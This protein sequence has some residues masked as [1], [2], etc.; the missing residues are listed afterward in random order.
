MPKNMSNEWEF[1]GKVLSWLQE[2][3]DLR[4]GLNL[5]QVTQEPSKITPKRNDLVVW[6]HRASGAA[7]LTFELKT[8]TTPIQD[9][10]LFADACEKARKWGARYFAIWNMQ[11]AELYRV[12][13]DAATTSL[14]DRIHLEP[15]NPSITSIDDWLNQQRASELKSVALR[16]LDK[17]WA[18]QAEQNAKLIEIEASVFVARLA[19]RLKALRACLYPALSAKASKSKKIKQRLKELATEQGFANFVDDIEEAISGQYAYRLIGQILFHFALRRRQPALSPLKINPKDP[20]PASF[21]PFWDEVRKF[22][23]EALFQWSE[24]DDIV[25]IPPEATLILFQMIEELSAYDWNKLRDDVLGAV[26]ERLIPTKERQ[27]L[28]QFYTPT[29]V[30]DLL[31]AFAVDGEDPFVLDPGCGSGTFVM[32]AYEYLRTRSPMKHGEALSKVW[33]FDISAFAAELASINLFRQDMSA[34]DNFPRIVCG[35][36]FDRFVGEERDFPPAKAGGQG[37]VTL[38]I[39]QFAAIVAN[40]PYLRSQNQDDL[41]TAYK[42][43]LFNSAAKNGVNANAKT[44][45]FAFFIY[46]S[47]EFLAPSGRLAFVVSSSWLTAD[48]GA[49]LQRVLLDKLKPVAIIMSQAESFFSQADVNAV[50][51]IAEKGTASATDPL[52]F[53]MLKRRLKEIFAGGGK[54]YWDSVEALAQEIESTSQSVETSEYRLT[55]VQSGQERTAMDSDT[56]RPRNWSLFLRAPSAYFQ[57]FGGSL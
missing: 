49:T 11:M 42:T 57:L 43:S 16:L 3:I 36:Y 10:I 37:K 44:D 39:P 35:N 55:V 45:L 26:F 31:I 30:A 54:P 4:P 17:A 41:S 53:V 20:L 40:P 33:G 21:K 7:F 19:E 29:E 51:L 15:L 32:R 9:P 5:E 2:E 28:G 48:F 13:A 8:P 25:P 56:S 18:D 6:L 52:R 38:E 24:L 47:L 27:L 14:A 12:A 22:D 34:F 50:M 46:K 23:Y 1:Q